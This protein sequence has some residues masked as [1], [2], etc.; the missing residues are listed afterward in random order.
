MRGNGVH[1][2]VR[3]IIDCR[4][5]TVSAGDMRRAGFE[6][7][8]NIGKGGFLKCHAADHIAAALIRRHGVEQVGLAIEHTDAARPIELVAGEGVEIHIQRLH[9][10]RAMHHGLGAIEQHQGALGVGQ[11]D[12]LV[13]RRDSA[14]RVRAMGDGNQAGTRAQ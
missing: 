3:D 9:I 12:N 5:E 14:E 10:D 13:N 11:A 6:A 8:G 1:A 2:D 4:R 7:A